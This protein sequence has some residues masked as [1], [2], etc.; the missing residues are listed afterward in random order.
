MLTPKK[1][2]FELKMILGPQIQIH[3]LKST[4]LGH[5]DGSAVEHLPSAQGLIPESQDRV[6][7]HALCMEPASLSTCVSASLCVSHA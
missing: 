4:L 1:H 2:T 3:C 7:H 6:P 5:L